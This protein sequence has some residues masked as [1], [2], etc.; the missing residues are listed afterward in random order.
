VRKYK[1]LL[2][3]RIQEKLGNL[4]ETFLIGLPR[5]CTI[6]VFLL[7]NQAI[8]QNIEVQIAVNLIIL[9]ALPELFLCAFKRKMKAL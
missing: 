7:N 2:E 9:M 1:D 3:L 4:L 6:F 5:N 8:K